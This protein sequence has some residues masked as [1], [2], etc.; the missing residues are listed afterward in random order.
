MSDFH[1]GDLVRIER[2]H[3]IVQDRLASSASAPGRLY[4]PAQKG[5]TYVDALRTHGWKVTVI[6]RAKPALPTE[7][8][9]Y[10]VGGN[11]TGVGGTVQLNVDK[12]WWWVGN[13][14][15][16]QPKKIDAGYITEFLAPLTRLEPV[17]ET[18]KKVLDR[19]SSW[20]EF[21]PPQNFL[22][23]FAAVAAEFGV[24]GELGE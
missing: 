8:G 21:G 4:L 20:W 15:Q 17:P 6:E 9:L 7:P 12:E 16:P 24:T 23:E 18:A 2:D 14:Y 10:C 22:D 1:E 3:V 11:T 19:L 13:E 5:G